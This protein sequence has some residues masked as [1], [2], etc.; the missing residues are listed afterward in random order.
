MPNSCTGPVRS[1][2]VNR[3]TKA[4]NLEL[5]VSRPGGSRVVQ[6][7]LSGEA[8]ARDFYP[9]RFDEVSSF[10]RKAAEV[11]GRFDRTARERAADAL[12]PSSDRAEARIEAFVSGDGYAV[13]TGQQPGLFGGPLYSVYKALTAVRLAE[14]LERHVERPVLPI[15]WVASEDHDWEEANH[16][17]LIGVD[18]ELKRYSVESPAG[19]RKPALH[20]IPLGSDVE[21]V[22]ERFTADLPSTDFSGPFVDNIREGF[23][24]GR[25]IADGFHSL[26][27]M[28]LG[29]Y[30]VAFVD[31]A[32][33]RLKEASQPLLLDELRRSE[34]FEGVLRG[35]ADRLEA[36]GYELQVPVLAGGVNAFLEGP[37][38]RERLYRDGDGFLLRSSGEAVSFTDVVER[39]NEDALSLSPNV[40][41]RP[42]VESQVFPTLAYV[43]GPGE[44]AYF[45]QLSAYFD[46]HGI[47]MPVIFPRYSATLIERKIRKVLDKFDVPLD[48]LR[49]PFH[50]VASDLARDD[51]PS[52]VK[53]ALGKI[54]GAVGGGVGELTKAVGKVDPTL[55]GTVQAFRGQAFSALDDVEKKIMQAVK[56]E[57]ETKLAQLE[58]AQLHIFPSGKPAERVQSPMYPLTRYG[59]GFVQAA[60]DAFEVNLE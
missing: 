5:I 20:R 1:G 10:T 43:A 11:D 2:A 44:M 24:P 8:A 41:S 47:A 31:A 30:G 28:I 13:T 33:L 15:F 21:A 53:S 58:K 40:L 45:A 3:T 27:K 14:A 16:A 48:D 34:E 25:T 29:P 60:Y 37:K 55:K 18:N 32:D 51:V 4:D 39:C 7:Y 35:T 17:D 26:L 36:A 19:D 23:A 12:T 50:E 9:L 56:R 38:G 42:V 57:S 52:E 59:A 49:R 46:A 6:D 54:R 22:L